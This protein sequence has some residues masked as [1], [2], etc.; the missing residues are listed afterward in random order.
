VVVD[1]LGRVI[2]TT[3]ASKA[4]SLTDLSQVGLYRAATGDDPERRVGFN[5]TGEN[6]SRHGGRRS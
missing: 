5:E 4:T 2:A 3:G 1:E 6:A